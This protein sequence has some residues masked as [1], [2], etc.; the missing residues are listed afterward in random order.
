MAQLSWTKSEPLAPG[1]AGTEQ[2]LRRMA[3]F[4]RRDARDLELRKVA[5]RVV[6]GC[7]GHDFEGE[8]KALFE[9][10]RDRI[11]YRR[12]P[13]SAEMVQDARGTLAAGVGDCDDKATLLS[14][15]LATLGH[16]SRFRVLAF[17]ETQPVN[18]QHVLLE[19]ELR[20]RGW[21]PLDPTPERSQLGQRAKSK[22]SRAYQ[23]WPQGGWAIEEA[24]P[25]RL[26]ISRSYGL[27]DL[28]AYDPYYTHSYLPDPEPTSPPIL[29]DYPPPPTTLPAPPA[30]PL[31]TP[32]PILIAPPRPAPMPMPLTPDPFVQWNRKMGKLRRQRKGGTVYTP[33]YI[34]TLPRPGIVTRM[35]NGEYVMDVGSMNGLEGTP[36][37][38]SAIMQGVGAIPVIGGA[39]S[40]VASLIGGLF[41]RGGAAKKAQQQQDAYQAEV[42]RQQDELAA[43]RALLEREQKRAGSAKVQARVA[44][45]KAARGKTDEATQHAQ[46]AL[47]LLRGQSDSEATAAAQATAVLQGGGQLPTPG[48]A[49][50]AYSVPAESLAQ[51]VQQP[52]Y[53][54]TAVPQSAP[55]ISPLFLIGG[56]VLLL[57]V[58]S[59]SK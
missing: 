26:P 31:P 52:A 51:P 27:G 25:L 37:L 13:V 57:V 11:T 33:P 45:K 24:S 59:Q 58:M 22:M 9:Y 39:I 17:R 23:I 32:P 15:L 12:D 48:G 54:T 49:I 34:P 4:V 8:V 43:E 47:I 53:Q 7:P 5:A 42:K 30:S 3:E 40:T 1:V 29:V 16:R 35:N 38:Q 46:S 55:G 41:G 19:V 18:W 10:V 56:G 44:V 28:A 21:I 50:D 14:T 36:F 20:G 6:A 2:T